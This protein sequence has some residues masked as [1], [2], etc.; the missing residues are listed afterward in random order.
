MGLTRWRATPRCRRPWRIA[1]PEGTGFCT[2][3]CRRGRIRI[4]FP[5]MTSST[6][7]RGARGG[8]LRD[9]LPKL[10]LRLLREGMID[11][12]ASPAGEGGRRRGPAAADRRCGRRFRQTIDST[13]MST[14]RISTRRSEVFASETTPA[15][16]EAG[17]DKDDGRPDQ[18]LP[19]GRDEARPA[20][21]HL[22]RGCGRLQPRR[23]PEERRGKGQGRCFQAHGWTAN[24]NTAA[25]G[26]S[27]RRWP[28]PISWAARSEWRTRGM[29]PVAE[30]QFFDYIWPAMHQLRNELSALRWRS[31]EL[32]LRRR[33]S[34]LPIGGY[35]TGG[36]LY[37]SQ[38]GRAFS[39]TRR[40]CAWSFRR[41]RSMRTACCAP[42]S[43]ATIR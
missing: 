25:I 16:A 32:S 5:T 21:H 35:L 8:E 3:A 24:A 30:I 31:N 17:P 40:E 34:A 43:A 9:P 33:S 13:T 12:E 27:T 28:R 11:A 6:A 37:H 15:A 39:P 22:W 29:K 10:Q 4:L 23:V 26:S 1:A 36:A 41:M 19:E 18:C 20:H 38:S 2:W 42:R 14:R 7:R